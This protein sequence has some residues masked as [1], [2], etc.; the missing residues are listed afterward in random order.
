VCSVQ[1]RGPYLL[2]GWS[3]GGILAYEMARQLQA[4]GEEVGLVA[5]IDAYANLSSGKA[6]TPESLEP[7]RLGALFYR[8][9]LRAT[10]AELPC[11]E[12]AL[13]RMPPDEALRVLEAAGRAAA[14]LPESGLQSLETLRRVF[15]DN[16]RAAW[17]YVPRPSAAALL[18]L[19]ASEAS[20]PHGWAALARGRVEVHTLE[21]DHYTLLRGD[22]LRRVASLLREALEGAHAL[23]ASL[24]TP[25][26]THRS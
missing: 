18:S 19:E 9:L 3:M 7:S 21:G 12:D 4:R 11:P 17:S 1:P 15:E 24:R 10:G 14:A 22:G 16:L 6:E 23:T 25:P 26:R 8:D 20:R 5:L 13:S 2:G